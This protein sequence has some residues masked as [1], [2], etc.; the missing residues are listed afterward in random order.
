MIPFF[1]PIRW[2]RE[3]IVYHPRPNPIELNTAADPLLTADPRAIVLRWEE[4]WSLH[5][6]ETWPRAHLRWSHGEIPLRP[7]ASPFHA[8]PEVFARRLEALVE[9]LEAYAPAKVRERGW[10]EIPEA[11]WERVRAL[12]EAP[13]DEQVGTGAFRS[14]PRPVEEAV[15]AER[16]AL[17]PLEAMLGWLA[18][19]PERPWRA[20]PRQVR[21]TDTYVYAE[22][23]DKSAWRLPLETLRGRRG[24]VDGDTVYVFGRQ[25]LLVLLH[26]EGC[27]VQGMLDARL[28]RAPRSAARAAPG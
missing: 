6:L 24:R 10:L 22:R 18:S 12:P 2:S 26:R 20:H 11:E 7:G 25:T 3:G 23:R 8:S 21:L 19:S 28:R 14:A 1:F 5:V 13:S 16:G 15:V 4:P 27:P 17:A 9:H